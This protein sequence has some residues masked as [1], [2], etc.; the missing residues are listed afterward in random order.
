MAP[1]EDVERVR[2]CH[3]NDIEV[4]FNFLIVIFFFITSGAEEETVRKSLQIYTI[5]RFLH[6]ICYVNAIRQ[7]FRAI[8]NT[9]C[10]LLHY[11]I[12]F[13]TFNRFLV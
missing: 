9:V 10:S 4:V 7:P 3:R 5:F 12:L 8:C 11:G 13:I 6:T 1:N 2:R